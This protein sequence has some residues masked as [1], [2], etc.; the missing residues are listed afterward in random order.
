M[1]FMTEM[2]ETSLKQEKSLLESLPS[3]VLLKILRF[4]SSEDLKTSF[5][6]CKTFNNTLNDNIHYLPKYR[7]TRYL[8]E[9]VNIQNSE[10]DIH[11]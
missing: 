9:E 2:E 1:E 5:L 3:E 6:V 11:F 8:I 7:I 10:H 4:L